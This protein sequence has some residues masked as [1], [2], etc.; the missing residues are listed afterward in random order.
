[1]NSRR[2]AL[3]M[4]ALGLI[5]CMVGCVSHDRHAAGSTVSINTERGRIV[6]LLEEDR[7]PLSSDFVRVLVN[8]GRFDGTKFYRASS[9]SDHNT[10]NQFVE[11]GLLSSFVLS[12]E[13][14]SFSATGLP[15]LKVLETTDQTGLRH[16]RG[17]VSLARDVMDTGAAIPDIVVYLS[18]A[19]EADA[20]GSYSPDGRGYPVFGQILEGIEIFDQLA[21][22]D[23]TGETWVPILQGQILTQPLTIERAEIR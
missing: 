14:T 22:E 13:P 2:Q 17:A 9:V 1:M 6:I 5:F 3:A 4:G 20:G 10:P 12:G 16:K 23:R 15:T 21:A 19:P 11:G 7:A 18:D 8:E